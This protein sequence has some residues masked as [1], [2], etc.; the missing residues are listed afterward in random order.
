MKT[1]N[2]FCI[3]LFIFFSSAD[4]DGVKYATPCE[5]CKIVTNELESRLKETG[6]SHDVIE[7]GYHIDVAKKSK[8]TYKSS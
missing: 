4:E 2:G 5:V 3:F 1:I 7:T 8:K 6:R